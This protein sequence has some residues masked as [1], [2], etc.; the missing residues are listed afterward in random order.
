MLVQT[1]SK[2]FKSDFRKWNLR[3]NYATAEILSNEIQSGE[4]LSVREIVIN[5]NSDFLLKIE[6]NI[7]VIIL[8][9]YGIFQI[10]EVNQSL[11]VNEV[12]T[13]KSNEYQEVTFSNNLVDEKA[14]ALI[15]EFY[16]SNSESQFHSGKF[17]LDNKNTFLPLIGNFDKP[18][19]IGLYEGRKEDLYTLENREKSIFGIVLNGA[20]EFQNRLL[21][22]RDA[23]L[24][25]EIEE[26]EFEALSENALI[27]FFEI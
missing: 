24:L 23:I 2:I 14:D 18:N 22:N 26:L 10:K 4:L 6:K 19:F 20:F 27:L 13:I 21:E 8:P 11:S 12:V 9:L 25:W 1:S 3:D 15:F 5:E 7:S 17:E 16:T